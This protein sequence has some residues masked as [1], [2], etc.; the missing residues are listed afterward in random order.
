MSALCKTS[1]STSRKET[2]DEMLSR[3]FEDPWVELNDKCEELYHQNPP[4]VVQQLHFLKLPCIVQLSMLPERSS[5]QR[6]GPVRAN[7]CKG[8]TL[9]GVSTTT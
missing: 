9:K 7:P 8:A 5:K 1:L 3:H 4:R 2:L 6:R